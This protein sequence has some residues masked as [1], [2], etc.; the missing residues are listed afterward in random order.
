MESKCFIAIRDPPHGRSEA[1][2]QR[3]VVATERNRLAGQRGSQVALRQ[4]ASSL[5]SQ[6][7]SLL[8]ELRRRKREFE[9]Q[10]NEPALVAVAAKVGSTRLIDN[11]VLPARK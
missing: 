1:A 2:A 4:Q 8:D 10:I 6:Q 9:G 11:T 7:S 5:I 3:N